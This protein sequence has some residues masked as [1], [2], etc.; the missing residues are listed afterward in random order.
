M[1]KRNDKHKQQTI[2]HITREVLDLPT[3][4]PRCRDALD[5]HELSVWQ[6]RQALEQAYEAGRVAGRS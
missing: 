4:D 3:L 2:T 5:F 6:I 1:P